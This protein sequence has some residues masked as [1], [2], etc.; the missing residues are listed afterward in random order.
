MK[1]FIEAET[2]EEAEEKAPA[3]TVV[4]LPC[5]GGFMAFDT[6]TDAEIWEGQE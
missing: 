2:Q 1:T 3:G 6:V 4:V 5:E